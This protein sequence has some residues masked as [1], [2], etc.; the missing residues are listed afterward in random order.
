MNKILNYIIKKMD[1]GNRIEEIE[2]I[3]YMINNNQINLK[4][5]VQLKDNQL[6]LKE[7]FLNQ[8]KKIP[9]KH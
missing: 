8:Y 5:I 3:D 6:S 9:N 4:S 1:S 7:F 2:L